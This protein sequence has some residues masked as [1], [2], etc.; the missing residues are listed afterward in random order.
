MNSSLWS[1]GRNTHL[2]IVAVALMASIVVVVV[3]INSRVESG[4][5]VVVKAGQPTVY[6][7]NGGPTIH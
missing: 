7:G 5:Q 2:K 4:S 3:G 6:T 1:A